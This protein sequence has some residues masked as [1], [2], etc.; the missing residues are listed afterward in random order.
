MSR[1]R[2]GTATVDDRVAVVPET[3]QNSIL[4]VK[5]PPWDTRLPPLGI[6]YLSSYLRKYG[7]D[8]PVWDCNIDTYLRFRMDRADLW[9]ME[10][11]VFWFTPDDVAD[12][13]NHECDIAARRI[14]EADTPYVGFS[15]TMEGINFAKLITDRLRRD[16]PDK[17]IVMGGP[18]VAF[19]EYRA[20]FPRGAVDI[21]VV[22]AGEEALRLL[23]TEGLDGNLPEDMTVWRDRPDDPDCPVCV[24][25]PVAPTAFEHPDFEGYDLVKYLGRDHI[26]LIMGRGCFRSCA[27][28]SDKP[29]QG[30]YR[31]FG[32]EKLMRAIAFYK[33]KLWIGGIT[34]NDLILNGD[35]NHLDRFCDVLLENDVELVWDG[36]M[37]AHRVMNKRPWLYE[38]MARAG[39]TDMTYG[40][41][42]FS[43]P[44]L[45][46]MRKGY[47]KDIA[48]ESLRLTREAGL[49]SGIN[50]ICGFPGESEADFQQTLDSLEE[51]RDV[52]DRVTS[53]SVCAVMP[54]S[55]LWTESE[56]F[57][58]TLPK[59][60]HYHEWE[61]LDGSN[62]LPMR[63]DRH[64]RMRAKVQELGLSAVV[65]A[66]DEFDPSVRT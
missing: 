43:D 15:L 14:L 49:T 1:L 34:W 52:I 48:V 7:L 11:A 46:I 53:L 64:A 12:V 45:A 59:P 4:L 21:F 8:A 33:E 28:C 35:L 51:H 17:I 40:L 31:S 55:P 41:E 50:L 22:G 44:V 29:D 24:S 66:T 61:T 47:T 30:K 36:Q 5:T 65:Q 2:S 27:F 18:G 20:L 57:G 6:G 3:K 10:A 25:H 54:G 38:K 32:F 37:T 62:T 23:L 39:C 63:I 26:A 56:K 19:P 58:I 16:A 42:S 13:F 60:G 9:D